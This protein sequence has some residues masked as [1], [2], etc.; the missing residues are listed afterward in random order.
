[1]TTSSF[2]LAEFLEDMDIEFDVI[3]EPD[4]NITLEFT[5]DSKFFNVLFIN[6][7][8]LEVNG[9]ITNYKNFITQNF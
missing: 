6:D 4:G 5:Y 9:E 3:P 1:M 7:N 8:D 2:K